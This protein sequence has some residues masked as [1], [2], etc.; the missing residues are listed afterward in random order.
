M[1]SDYT[2][3]KVGP[4]TRDTLRAVTNYGPNAVA[5]LSAATRAQAGPQAAL[6]AQ[7]YS[8]YAPGYFNIGEGFADQ[9]AQR[10]TQRDLA[11]IQGGGLDLARQAIALD[12]EA[13]PEFYSNRAA[14]GQGFQALLAGQDPNKLT[15]SE[16]AN[17]ERGVNR[18]NTSRGTPSNIGDATTTASNAMMFGDKLNQKRAMFGQSL[19]LFPGIQQ[20]SQSGINA[21]Q[22]AAGR[23]ASSGNNASLQQYKGS[24]AFD[25]NA[26]YGNTTQG[27]FGVQQQ[28]NDI[29]K[30]HRGIADYT[31]QAIGSVCCF[32]FLEAY[33][34]QLPE[35]VRLCRDIYYQ[36]DPQLATGYKRMATWLVPMMRKS[37]VVSWL[38]NHTMVKPITRYGEWLVGNKETFCVGDKMIRDFWFSIWKKG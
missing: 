24:Q 31:N 25:Q 20:G 11:T 2:P 38:V 33:N 35:S 9:Q 17:V 22:I 28:R 36:S 6:D 18:L 10:A 7:L 8:Q 23:G 34:G 32:I 4:Q 27:A 16:M 1:G 13:N 14:A 3:P 15:G 5:A 29:L 19:A 21:Y 26:M 37:R 12:R 30:D